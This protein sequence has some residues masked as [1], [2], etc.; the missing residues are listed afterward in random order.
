VSSTI[1][2]LVLILFIEF[3]VTTP[4][5][6]APIISSPSFLLLIFSIKLFKDCIFDFTLDVID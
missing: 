5:A 2:T 3:K 4:L 6:G 1:T